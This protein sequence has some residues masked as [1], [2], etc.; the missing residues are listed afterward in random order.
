MKLLEI[1]H[2]KVQ[3]IHVSMFIS[4]NFIIF[5]HYNVKKFIK[6]PYNDRISGIWISP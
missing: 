2:I 6:R 1:K 5:V 3:I 4:S